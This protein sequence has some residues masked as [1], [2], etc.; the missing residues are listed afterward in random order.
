M[1]KCNGTK[2]TELS[3]LDG[4]DLFSNID[5]VSFVCTG[6][7]NDRSQTTVFMATVGDNDSIQ[8]QIS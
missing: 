5:L 2:S 1:E 8:F 3:D 6:S 4:V 7:N